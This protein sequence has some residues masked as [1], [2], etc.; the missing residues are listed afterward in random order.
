MLHMLYYYVL[1]C[2]MD[3]PMGDVCIG[4]P[5]ASSADF[6][7]NSATKQSVKVRERSPLVRPG[8]SMVGRVEMKKN[9]K[10][11]VLLIIVYLCRKHY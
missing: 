7:S 10:W 5:D 11:G 8:G 6:N 2:C 3:R 4:R 1:V 9:R